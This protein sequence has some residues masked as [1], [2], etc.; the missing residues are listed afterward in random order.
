MNH[1]ETASVVAAPVDSSHGREALAG[2]NVIPD[3]YGAPKRE[4]AA[5]AE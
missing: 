5:A 4:A 1:F 2:M 3:T